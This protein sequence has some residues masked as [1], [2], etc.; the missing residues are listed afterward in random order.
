M[1]RNVRILVD[2]CRKLEENKVEKLSIRKEVTHIYRLN[3]KKLV[4][5]GETV[6]C[7]I[8]ANV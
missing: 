2:M 3:H 5:V 6:H 4:I 1:G 7:V 8:Y